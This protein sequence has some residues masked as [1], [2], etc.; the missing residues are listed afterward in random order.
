MVYRDAE[1]ALRQRRDELLARRRLEVARLPPVVRS[2]YARREARRI[3]GA[4]GIAG[5]FVLA[6]CAALRVDGLT[7]ILQGTW[8][9]MILVYILARAVADGRLRRLL[10]ATF[11]PGEDVA[12]DLLR[13]EEIGPQQVVMRLAAPIERKS[14][15]LPMIALALLLPLTLHFVVVATVR[16]EVPRGRDFDGWI[17]MS[18]LFVGHC[19]LVLAYHAWS[20]AQKLRSA[21]EGHAMATIADRAG[22]RAWGV[23]IAWSVLA[24]FILLAVV[25]IAGIA[26]FIV[27]PVLVGA[28][29][30]TFIPAMFSKMGRKVRRE[31]MVLSEE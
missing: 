22:W 9:S 20:F 31:R 17:S 19:H 13:F 4:V 6:V 28:T 21:R 16:G 23:T 18:L 30:L 7:T 11:A 26:L 15:A 10:A 1:E 25:P 3:T 27:A 8:I 2:V 12:G 14:V 29:G 24:G 5:A